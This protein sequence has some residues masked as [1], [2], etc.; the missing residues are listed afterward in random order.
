MNL[1]ACPGRTCGTSSGVI[2]GLYERAGGVAALSLLAKKRP[3]DQTWPVP[4]DELERGISH[5][6]VMSRRFT[7][8]QELISLAPVNFQTPLFRIEWQPSPISWPRSLEIYRIGALK[9]IP[10][11]STPAE[12][13]VGCPYLSAKPPALSLGPA[14]R[15]PRGWWKSGHMCGPFAAFTSPSGTRRAV[16]SPAAIA[17]RGSRAPGVLAEAL[18]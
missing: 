7:T 14:S 11:K 2:P 4:S 8:R 1:G 18:S 16:W 6:A 17:G 15:A 5:R 10:A 12:K 9:L 3:S 13:G